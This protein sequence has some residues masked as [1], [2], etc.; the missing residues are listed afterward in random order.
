M[1]ARQV[2]GDSEVSKNRFRSNPNSAADDSPEL[3]I[4]MIRNDLPLR[5]LRKV[6]IVPENG[7]G[8]VRGAIFMTLLCWFR[9]CCGHASAT[10]CP[11]SQAAPVHPTL[12][13][14]W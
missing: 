11:P 2:G 6:G 1:A 8:T 9:R 5:W 7:L 13:M 12:G 10:A 4:E 14:A 3:E